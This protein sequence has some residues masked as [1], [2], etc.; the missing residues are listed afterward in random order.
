MPGLERRARFEQLRL[1]H[2][3]A[4]KA[5]PAFVGF[6][7]GSNCPGN[8]NLGSFVVDYP[9][10]KHFDVYSGIAYSLAACGIRSGYLD[11]NMTVLLSGF[12]L[13]F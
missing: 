1:R 8:F 7:N 2:T 9:R 11:D 5:N 13:K 4:N 6:A 10:T 12:R 3:A